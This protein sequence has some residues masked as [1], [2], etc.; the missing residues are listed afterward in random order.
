[1]TARIAGGKTKTVVKQVTFERTGPVL[2]INDIPETTQS[3]KIT[4]SGTVES[5]SDDEYSYSYPDVYLNNELI[6]N[7]WSNKFEST[8]KLSEGKNT[9]VFE[10]KDDHGKITTVTKTVTLNV[11]GPV[12]K[13]D[14]IPE[15]TSNSSITL[16]G[17]IE[18]PNDNYPKFYINDELINMYSKTFSRKLSLQEGE[19]TFTFVAV[20]SSGKRTTETRTIT[21]TSDGPKLMVDYIPETTTNKKLTVSWSVSDSNDNSPK[22]YVNDKYQYYGTSTTIDLVPG[23]N[24][25]TFKATNKLGKSTTVTKTITLSVPGP[26]LTV[27]YIPET[28]TNKKL[29]VTWNVT[30]SN[31]QNPKVYVNDKYQYYATSTTIDLVPGVNTITFKATNELGLST[32]VTKTITLSVPGPDLTV[33][34]IPET[35]TN[36]KLNVTWNVTDS[37]DQNPKVYVNDKYQYY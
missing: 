8:V 2:K 37:N 33:G 31:D 24:T 5:S 3:E 7:Y 1:M 12:I 35:T 4:V 26:E 16:S 34:Y 10:A 6:S 18:D 30:D 20:N 23:V 9:L 17:T 36:K 15:T 11:G 14:Y 21:L 27:G 22:V 28:T 29:N 19:N 13:F 32:T 25:I